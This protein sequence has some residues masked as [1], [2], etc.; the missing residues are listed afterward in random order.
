MSSKS[1]GIGLWVHPGEY[2][3]VVHVKEP[4]MPWAR[5]AMRRLWLL[6]GAF[7]VIL[8]A[9]EPT[10][11]PVPQSTPW[12]PA[13]PKLTLLV[14]TASPTHPTVTV[15][16]VMDGDTIDVNIEGQEGRLRLIGVDT[17]EVYGQEECFGRAASEFAK[18]L[19]PPGPL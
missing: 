4:E 1:Q 7:L 19:L 12:P 11:T 15:V 16:S 9:C 5:G 17:P 2:P 18:S 6:L 13:T 10:A 3:S 14:P 8:V